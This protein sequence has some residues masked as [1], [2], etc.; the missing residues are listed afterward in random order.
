MPAVSRLDDPSALPVFLSSISAP[1][2][3]ASA[4]KAAG[5][6][7]LGTLAYALSDPSDPELVT[8]SS[9]RFNFGR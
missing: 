3:L 7:T 6:N 9:V 8:C 2:S 5:Y 1:D 4:L